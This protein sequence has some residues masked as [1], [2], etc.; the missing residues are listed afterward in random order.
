MHIIQVG[1]A[2]RGKGTQ[3]IHRRGRLVIGA[4]EA[5]RIGL[6]PLWREGHVID[7]V[8]AIAR[9]GDPVDRLHV[10]RA[11]LGELTG[12]PAQLHDWLGGGKGQHHGHL[13]QDAKS[14]AHAFGRE[15]LEAL[16]T[17][18]ALKQ[19]GIARR[20]VGQL[21]AQAPCFAGKYQRRTVPQ[22]CDGAIKRRRICIIGHLLDAFGAP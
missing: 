2:A 12:N 18:A 10:R 15:L 9:Q 6:T 5:L 3:Q 1:I 14:V 7:A 8:A 20:D 22:F 19:E 11:R 4:Q 17:I 16:C 21:P 13:Q